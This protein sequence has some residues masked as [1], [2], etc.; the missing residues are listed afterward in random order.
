MALVGANALADAI[1]E[2]HD[3]DGAVAAY[4]RE[5]RPRVTAAQRGAS[6]GASVLVPKTAGG[7]ALRNL[8]VRV[9]RRV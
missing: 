4:E 9:A 8:L 2:T 1:A 7:I 5:H 6:Y 3:V